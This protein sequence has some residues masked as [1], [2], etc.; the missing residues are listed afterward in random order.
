VPSNRAHH[1]FASCS[2]SFEPS[3]RLLAQGHGL[4]QEVSTLYR[5]S[6]ARY[7]GHM[8]PGPAPLT[9]TAVRVTTAAG[10]DGAATIHAVDAVGKWSETRHI[11]WMYMAASP[12]TAAAVLLLQRSTPAAGACGRPPPLGYVL[13]R[14][15]GL[16]RRDRGRRQLG[17]AVR[18][19]QPRRRARPAAH[20]RQRD[21]VVAR[22]HVQPD[23]LRH[24]HRRRLDLPGSALPALSSVPPGLL[25]APDARAERRRRCWAAPAHRHCT[26]SVIAETH[27]CS[28][29]GPCYTA[30]PMPPAGADQSRQ[31]RTAIARIA[32]YRPFGSGEIQNEFALR[33]F[34]LAAA[35]ENGGAFASLAACREICKTLWGLEIE[36]DELRDVMKRLQ[37]SGHIVKDGGGYRLTSG[38]DEALTTRVRSSTETEAKAF[39]E[40][41]R[42]VRDLASDLSEEDA[43][44]LREDLAEWLNH[45]ITRYGLEA[46]LLLYPEQE[47]AA[48]TLADIE[49]LGMDFL[50]ER[51]QELM[52][53]RPKALFAF[54]RRP[55][56][57]QRTY[58]ANL[59]TTAYL[60]SVFT[61]APE[62][63]AAVQAVT[64]GQRVYLDTNV[65]YTLLNLSGPRAFLSIRRVIEMTV[66]LGYEVCVT[67]WTVEEMKKSVR[68]ARNQLYKTALPPQALADLAAEASGDE[69]FVTAYWRKYKET[70]VSPKDFLDLHE[71]IEALIEK[72]GV[73]I[74]ATST[75]AIQRDETAISNQIGYLETVP[76][77]ANKTRKIQEHDVKHRLLVERLRGDGNR[78]F[79]NAGAWF[80]TQDT[81]LIPY[82]LVGRPDGDA[83]PFTVSVTA[84]AHIVRSLCPRTTDYEQTLV[85]LL[86]SPSVRPRGMVSYQTVAEVL[87]RID[88]LVHDSTEEIATRV[89]LDTAAMHGVEERSGADR[90]AF[91]TEAI[92]TKQAG[93]ERQL[94][95]TQEQVEQERVQRTAAEQRAA[96]TAEELEHER[97]ARV[98]AERRATETEQRRVE[99]EEA[100][101]REAEAEDARRAE[102]AARDE[103]LRQDAEAEHAAELAA[104]TARVQAKD[105]ALRSIVTV[106]IGAVGASVVAVPLAL[107]W[108]TD[109]WPLIMLI[110]GGL[111]V[112]CA[113]VAWHAGAKRAFAVV[114]AVGLALGIISALHDIVGDGDKPTTSNTRSR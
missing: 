46:A 35:H 103:E 28:I 36:I 10:L 107:G 37:G 69:N 76:G 94:R 17:R 49:E 15:T 48:S 45:I 18:P 111:I 41:E 44:C 51:S 109:G 67:P 11:F 7:R 32:Q 20:M 39:E 95:E 1:E 61:L 91:L 4:E 100:A 57:A 58:L 99:E 93:M 106:L 50:P 24:R 82:S 29:R 59:M 60:V 19:H 9:A 72:A 96:T 68:S 47:R 25:R 23:P 63:H 5:G 6:R 81:V 13:S 40:W 30:P 53:L 56:A 112:A 62:A 75:I 71:Q 98:L 14:T 83:L 114:G 108:V 66:S 87:G 21:M 42:S 92:E 55:T 2:L 105:R 16:P 26:S 54:I 97:T 52:A 22:R 88:M 78:R 33:E 113:A 70:G 80:L 43:A 65:V 86:D 38:A 84:W 110:L 79:S 90:D 64:S 3:C 34:V 12:V 73:K 8:E 77:G 85:D 27:P 74:D 89:L 102:E 101:R 104:L 31:L